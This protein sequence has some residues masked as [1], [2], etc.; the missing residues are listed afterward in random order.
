LLRSHIIILLEYQFSGVVVAFLSFL[1]S[2]VVAC[3]DK[4]ADKMSYTLEEIKIKHD[5]IGTYY[6]NN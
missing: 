1:S 4:R 2:V 5:A 6:Q 3:L